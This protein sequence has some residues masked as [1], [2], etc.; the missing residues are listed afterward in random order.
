VS[1]YE[2]KVWLVPVTSSH[3]PTLRTWRNED[4]EFERRLTDFYIKTT[5]GFEKSLRVVS[6]AA[7]SRSWAARRPVSPI[8]T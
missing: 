5:V 8:S 3:L 2:E 1:E 6:G 7:G 4:P